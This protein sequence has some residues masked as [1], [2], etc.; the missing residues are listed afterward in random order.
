MIMKKSEDSFILYLANVRLD[1]WSPSIIKRNDNNT[2]H[3]EA[4]N[5]RLLNSLLSYLLF[6]LAR[7]FQ[8]AFEY[9]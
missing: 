6:V 8:L 7:H 2:M 9:S 3:S 5:Q 1:S 4:L